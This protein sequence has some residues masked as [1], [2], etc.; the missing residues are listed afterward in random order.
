MLSFRS[1]RAMIREGLALSRNYRHAATMR[2]R[3]RANYGMV[4]AWRPSALIG[5]VLV[6]VDSAPWRR[7]TVMAAVLVLVARR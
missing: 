4:V 7:L 6:A 1:A 5:D 2:R 3:L